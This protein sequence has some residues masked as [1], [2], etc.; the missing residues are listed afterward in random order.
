[1]RVK[2]EHP[3]NEGITGMGL[4]WLGL[5]GVSNM[6]LECGGLQFPGA[7]FAGWYQST[8]VANRDFLD[9]QRYNLL[10]P[11]AEAMDLDTSSD[12]TLWKDEVALEMNRAVLHSYKKAGVSIVDHFTQ[13]DQFMNHLREETRLRGG[14]PADW[15]W[16]VPPQSGSL[17]PTFHQE[18]LNYH[19]SPSFEYQVRYFI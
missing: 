9:P 3:S 17:V 19:M 18:M 10:Y 7:P 8:E 14:C 11:I 15:V 5:P 12:A 13:A 16:I 1:M 2:I 4:E 6:M